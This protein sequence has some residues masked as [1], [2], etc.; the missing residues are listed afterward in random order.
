MRIL[1]ALVAASAGIASADTPSLKLLAHRGVA[2]QYHREGLGPQT[3]TASRILPP[4]HGYLENTLPSIAEAFRLGADQV[5]ID[6]HP[7]TDGE[8]VIFHDWRLECRTDG[9]GV[10][11]ERPLA[12]LKSLDVG[13]GYTADGGATFPF[14]GKFVGAMPTWDE[15]MKAFPGRRFQVNIKSNSADEGRA[16]VAYARAHGYGAERISFIGGDR[17]IEAIHQEWPGMR[18]LSRARLKSCL[19]GHV[20]LGWTGHTPEACRDSTIFVPI[21]Y[22]GWM[23]GWPHKFIERMAAVN[24]EVFVVGPYQSQATHYG[25]TGIDTPADLENLKDYA[26]GIVA[27]RIDLMGPALRTGSAK[28]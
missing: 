14:R 4:T 9:S 25:S 23:W 20:L 22:I 12:Y 27:D 6:I 8:F 18:T 19:V 3:C 13:H 15:V 11:R 1:L 17:P 7:T 24:S 26:G 28:K 16:A 10:T 21:N 2:Q 5:E